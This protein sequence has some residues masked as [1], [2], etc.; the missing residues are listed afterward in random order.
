MRQ[1]GMRNLN[2]ANQWITE[3]SRIFLEEN[4]RYKIDSSGGVH[5]SIDEEFERARGASIA[6]L[7]GPRY[8]NVLNAFEQ[9]YTEL[10]AVPPD[11]KGAIRAAF[12][13]AEGL[14]RLMFPSSPRLTAGEID[15]HLGPYLQSAFATDATA[16]GATSKLLASFKDWVDSAH[17]YRHE[18]GKEEIAQPPLTLAINLVSLGAS[19]IRWLA[20]MD[21]IT[22]AK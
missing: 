14:F 15:K 1:K 3:A 16:L 13:A 8:S 21:T 7:Q 6:A 19:Y 17:F 12:S 2:A 5:F 18:P 4:V 22:Q 9:A 20:E 11:G 10:T